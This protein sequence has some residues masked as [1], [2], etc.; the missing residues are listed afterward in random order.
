[1]LRHY[2]VAL[3]ALY[4]P[5]SAGVVLSTNLPLAPAAVGFEVV[6]DTTWVASDFG[7]DNSPYLLTS[8]SVL[9]Y[10]LS[11][12]SIG[13]LSADIWSDNAGEPGSLV[14]TL[15]PA[16]PPFPAPFGGDFYEST[17]D[18]GNL[19]LAPM[20]VYWVVLRD[21]SGPVEWVFGDAP[22]G[23]GARGNWGRS[24]DS[25]VTWETHSGSPQIMS[26]VANAVPEP[27]TNYLMA[28]ALTAASLIAIRARVRHRRR[29]SGR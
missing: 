4:A 12:G 2:L 28:S 17:F 10:T 3:T 14:G 27:G 26:V 1:M 24:L 5:L 16:G 25:G 29:E 23:P 22:I 19:P 21:A 8:V 18:G 20:S 13:T 15:G 9:L 6:T 7:T 11:P